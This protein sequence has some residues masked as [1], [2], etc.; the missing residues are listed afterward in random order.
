[1]ILSFALLIQASTKYNVLKLDEIDGG[2]STTNRLHFLDVLDRQI[3]MLEIEQCF[4]ISHNS[5]I[6]FSDVDLILLKMDQ[7]EV[8]NVGNVIYR[9]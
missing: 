8:I 2:L 1:M 3:N 5:E 9:Y 7:S 4:M 6:D